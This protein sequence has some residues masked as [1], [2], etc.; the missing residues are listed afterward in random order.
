MHCVHVECGAAG[1]GV[2]VCLPRG[3]A[4]AGRRQPAL[5]AATA[6]VVVGHTERARTACPNHSRSR[7]RADITCNRSLIPII[8]SNILRNFIRTLITSC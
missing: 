8:T 1:R 6:S 3:G 7:L 2:G 5:A 4:A